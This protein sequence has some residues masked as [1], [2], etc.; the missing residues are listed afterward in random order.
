MK[1]IPIIFK[2]NELQKDLRFQKM[3]FSYKKSMDHINNYIKIVAKNTHGEPIS[4]NASFAF[5]PK[6]KSDKIIFENVEIFVKNM[7]H[8]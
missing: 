8:R 7:S 6:I 1:E 2:E 4:S 3:E 5:E